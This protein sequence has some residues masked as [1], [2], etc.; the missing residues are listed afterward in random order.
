[1][2]DH[3]AMLGRV[4]DGVEEARVGRLAFDVLRGGEGNG[5]PDKFYKR[6]RGVAGR[7]RDGLEEVDDDAALAK[8]IADIRRRMR[9]HAK[10]SVSEVVE[11]ATAATEPESVDVDAL[12][13]ASVAASVHI[14]DR[15][16][17]RHKSVL[18][19]DA[20][21]REGN[22][23]AGDSSMVGPVVDSRKWAKGDGCLIECVAVAPSV[24]GCDATITKRMR[25]NAPSTNSHA[26]VG[27]TVNLSNALA[28][29]G[30]PTT[31]SAQPQQLQLQLQLQQHTSFN[32]ALKAALDLY[33]SNHTVLKNNNNPAP[34]VPPPFLSHSEECTIK[35]AL[36]F[37]IAKARIRN[38]K[39][40]E[41]SSSGV[42]GGRAHLPSMDGNADGSR[43]SSFNL[44][45]DPIDSIAAAD[46]TR[47]IH[48][49]DSSRPTLGLGGK[50]SSLLGGLLS[51]PPSR[52]FTL[53][54]SRHPTNNNGAN[55]NDLELGRKLKHVQD[56][57]KLA[58]SAVLPLY[59]GAL[60]VNG[61]DLPYVSSARSSSSVSKN[62]DATTLEQQSDDEAVSMKDNDAYFLGRRPCAV[63]DFEAAVEPSAVLNS[64]P[65]LSQPSN[66]ADRHYQATLD[67]LC[68]HVIIR[69]STLIRDEAMQSSS[70]E[71]QIC[72]W[73]VS[74]A[75]SA[76]E[77]IRNNFSGKS[78]G[79]SNDDNSF[80]VNGG[81]QAVVT[82]KGSTTI[83]MPYGK[84]VNKHGG[85][86]IVRDAIVK[87]IYN[88]LI[89]D[90]C[91]HRSRS[92]HT[93]QRSNSSSF[94]RKYVERR[95]EKVMAVC[96]VLHRLLFLDKD[97][98]LG[99]ECVVVIC[100]ILSDLYLNQ[101]S[102][103]RFN[104]CDT[105]DGLDLK[106]GESKLGKTRHSSSMVE[107]RRQNHHIQK[108]GRNYQIVSSRWSD[109]YSASNIIERH[110]RRCQSV[111]IPAR[112]RCSSPNRDI[113][114]TNKI[115]LP[116]P[117]IGDVLAVNLLRLLEGA[118][119]IRLHHRQESVLSTCQAS[120][121]T[122]ENY[123]VDN[124]SSMAATE[125]LAEIRSTIRHDL[126]IPLH[127]EDGAKFY[128]NKKI[129]SDEDIRGARRGKNAGDVL[130]LLQP[131][132]K[133]MLRLH[134][135][136]LMTK[137]ALYERL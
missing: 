10:W 95:I 96:H 89:G 79:G 115:V 131:G 70:G 51:P 7:G 57:L 63:Y 83:A 123:M 67:G 47:G 134:L 71:L 24:V 119:A 73:R 38:R 66:G 88:D 20:S 72:A 93:Q 74:T 98:C 1:M 53:S 5:C 36:A 78:K 85:S 124:A 112:R 109:S 99:T 110:E 46:G 121:R 132:A 107:M 76:I 49:V 97:C 55:K 64:G 116:L 26:T 101:Y 108:D 60:E 44:A 91:H 111:D 28:S 69:L 90:A 33:H 30:S 87:L 118:A 128:Y 8:I 130:V 133:M 82:D 32:K 42:R 81:T 94:A 39:D 12:R 136:D 65:F 59:R 14:D 15:N 50:P 125:V 84:Q 3:F 104:N 126:I 37:V 27:E 23:V 58:V 13:H 105:F 100:S 106:D 61:C 62:D 52:L 31:D 25:E 129:C 75:N 17:K 56:V 45:R 6:R 92:S 43:K 11:P 9:T 86:S 35:T 117:H 22:N 113:A 29:D 54:S 135:F 77:S 16:R 122:D 40:N 120:S 21:M 127:V 48:S 34:P 68:Q 80:Y 103:T 137:I 4:R 114:S 19:A 41:T 2:W 18:V 102:G